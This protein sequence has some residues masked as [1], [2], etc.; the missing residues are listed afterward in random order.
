MHRSTVFKWVAAFRSGGS[1]ALAARPVPG[2]PPRLTPAQLRRVYDL[3]A[4]HNPDQLQFDFALW[5]RDLVRQL[6]A[7][8]FGVRLSLVS[9]GRWLKALGLSPQKPLYRAYQADPEAVAVWKAE[10]Y[11]RIHA[12]AKRL[13]ATIWFADEASVRSDYHAGTTWAPVGRTPVVTATG[14][15]FSVNMISAVSAQGALRFSIV[16]GTHD[17]A[18]VHRLLQTS[19]PRLGRPGTPGWSTGRSSTGR[20]GTACTPPL[21]P[22]GS[23]CAAGSPGTPSNGDTPARGRSRPASNPGPTSPRYEH[24]HPTSNAYT[25]YPR[26]RNPSLGADL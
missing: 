16:D 20:A 1:D 21:S 3:I 11:P 19:R 6:I 5:T 10:E 14:A 2:R 22:P 18:E 13:G 25:R 26:K 7:R 4:G 12:E 24:G 15:R 9:V 17:R 8:E 23:N